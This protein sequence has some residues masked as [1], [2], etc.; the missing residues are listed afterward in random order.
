MKV[1]IIEDDAEVAEFISLA[2]E[3]GWPEA[4]LITCHHGTQGIEMIQKESPDVVILD[5]GLPDID[6][7]EVIKDVRDF[8]SVPIIIATVRATEADIVKGLERGADEY[9]VKPFGQLELLARVK[10]VLRR[11]QGREDASIICGQLRFDPLASILSFG[12]NTVHVTRTEGYILRELMRNPNYVVTYNQLAD[13][14]WGD[15]YP[16]APEALRVYIRRLRAKMEKDLQG[17]GLIRTSPG[18]GYIL[19]IPP[20]P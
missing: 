10:A 9:L 6:G 2:F 20:S 5:L 14:I 19:E 12:K 3:V 8:S 16:N 17:A 15:F 13:A 4:R 7:I 11:Q 18:A 1:L